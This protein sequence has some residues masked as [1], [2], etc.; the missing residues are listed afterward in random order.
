MTVLILFYKS[1]VIHV[2]S[3]L[4]IGKR[5]NSK[6]CC[7]TSIRSWEIWFIRPCLELPGEWE[8]WNKPGSE[9]G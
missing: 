5:V 7:G 1:C 6:S 8:M 9:S 2:K 3:I 4:E